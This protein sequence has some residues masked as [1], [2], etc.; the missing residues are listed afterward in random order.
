MQPGN[1]FNDKKLRSLLGDV[2]IP[3]ELKDE[4]REIPHL[5]EQ[6]TL[7]KAAVRNGQRKSTRWMAFAASLVLVATLTAW[8][9][10]DWGTPSQANRSTA[11]R[12]GQAGDHPADH[13]QAG[14]TENDATGAIVDGSGLQ[15]SA[16]SV[17]AVAD[18]IIE[19]QEL[20]RLH[21]QLATLQRR[22]ASPR[23]APE[24]YEALLTAMANE[25]A[26]DMG[27]DTRRLIAEL[28][29]VV[30]KFPNTTGAEYARQVINT[31]TRSN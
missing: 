11:G 20:D 18:Q 21:R 8:L 9:Y 22:N 1:D 7:A 16:E 2:R 6:T 28:N 25:V 12:V 5:A 30:T 19:T 4:L 27:G 17:Q 15:I 24:E 26:L 31:R 23:L 13:G 3:A 29:S 14:A 10:R